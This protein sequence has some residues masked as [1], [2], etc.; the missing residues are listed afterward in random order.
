MGTLNVDKLDPESGT[1]L[2]IGTSG[3][4]IT[5]PS[6]ATLTTTNATV[7]L[8]AS[9]GGLG[10]GID[11]TSQI[12]GVV[13]PANLGTG[14]AS[15]ST[16]LYGDGTF[17]AEPSGGLVLLT[18]DTS[19]TGASSY[20]FDHFV[21]GTYKDY[22]VLVDLWTTNANQQAFYM[23]MRNA[24]GDL[25]GSNYY[26]CHYGR[27]YD[28]SS[29]SGK[30]EKIWA[31]TEFPTIGYGTADTGSNLGDYPAFAQIWFSNITSSSH[32]SML[33]QAESWDGTAAKRDFS[34]S[35]IYKADEDIRGFTLYSS[36][37]FSI[38]T[39]TTYGIVNV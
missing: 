32:P 31:G 33:F 12:T 30:Y 37:T 14:S 23:R 26:G 25:T 5:V 17:K 22:L 29:D 24:S 6:G 20:N 2:E 9:V 15:S 16:V 18:K 35:G 21:N 39:V 11:V 13:P 34:G 8:P 27:T 10:T 38:G 4:T 3:D 36:G 7:N 19:N 1:A 28:S